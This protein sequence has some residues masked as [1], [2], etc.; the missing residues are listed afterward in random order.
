MKA[1]RVHEFGGP[2]VLKLEDLPDLQPGPGQ[3]VVRVHAVGVNPVENYMRTGTYAIK[4]ALPY[5]PGADA[6][7]VVETVGTGVT[8]VK[9]GDRVYTSG[10]L[11]GT[12]A[13][14]TLCT[15]AQVHALPEN[16]SFEQGAAM[17]VA[18]GTAYRALFQRGGANPGETVLIHGASGG[19]GTA[20]VQLARA[21]KL[22]VMGTASSDAGMHLVKEQGAQH[23]VN[24]STPGY[25]E[26]LMTLTGG[27]GFDMIVEMLANKNLAADMS[28]LA[29]KG[30]V[31]VV[32]NRGTIEINPR[33]LM[34]R[35]ADVR[36]VLLFGTSEQE[37]REMHAA[38]GD[39]L[40]NGALRPV[41][42]QKILLAEAAHAHEQIMKPAGAMGKIVL[43][44]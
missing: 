24:H 44:V 32:G 9:P 7:G 41:I 5:T 25:L 6:A 18:Y 19:V 42:A 22:L 8:S 16:V 36:G 4:P 26:E 10:S 35:E 17:G 39:G 21:A 2:E 43:V 23:A 13:E 38:L 3:V 1:I 34:S 31:V 27:R 40:K 29:K 33:D 20:A 28:L 12:Y 37:A 11:S 30:R 15:E 14:Q